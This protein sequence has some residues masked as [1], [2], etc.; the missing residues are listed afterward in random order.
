V[1]QL[2]QTLSNLVN[3]SGGSGSVTALSN[4]G[5]TFNQDGKLTFNQAQFD[6]IRQ[7]DPADVS[8][9]LGSASGGGFLTAATNALNTLE[10]PTSGAFEVSNKNLQSQIDKDNSQITDDT[11]RISNMQTT[12]IAQMSAAD[13][14]IA[15]LQ[16]E[17]TYFTNLFA[18]TQNAVRAGG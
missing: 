12:L 7:S 2:Q 10:D 11:A 6:S 4:L 17:V 8:G 3:Y 18:D 14:A 1:F 15:K 9:F 5:I 13:A 16:S